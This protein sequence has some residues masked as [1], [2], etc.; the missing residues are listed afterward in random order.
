M[1]KVSITL[2]YQNI[3]DLAR[4]LHEQNPLYFWDRGSNKQADN[5]FHAKTYFIYFRNYYDIFSFMPRC[6]TAHAFSYSMY[7]FVY[8]IIQVS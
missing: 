2:S 5:I 6:S 7:N 4:E 1:I 3:R 8:L